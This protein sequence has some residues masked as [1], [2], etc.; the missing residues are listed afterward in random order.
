VIGPAAR[1]AD[2][3]GARQR[4][5]LALEEMTLRGHASQQLM[6]MTFTSSGVTEVSCWSFRYFAPGSYGF[7]CFLFRDAI[8]LCK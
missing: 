3:S 1:V 2:C 6:S 7:S 8:A 5:R 4:D